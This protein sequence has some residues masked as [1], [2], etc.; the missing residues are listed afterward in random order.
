MLPFADIVADGIDV[1]FQPFYLAIVFDEHALV[2]AAKIHRATL[3]RKYYYRHL[4]A[5][6]HNS[7]AGFVVFV[8]CFFYRCAH[9]VQHHA[10]H[11]W[12]VGGFEVVDYVFECAHA[13]HAEHCARYAVSG[14]VGGYYH[15][16]TIDGGR[17]IPVAAYDVAWA[18]VHKTICKHFLDFRFV[19]NGF[20]LYF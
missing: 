10:G 13:E 17:I 9:L 6:V 4:H 14:T 11:H 2:C 3:R 16:V 8:E 15:F 12:V 20:R 5:V 19:A 18:V 7:L 1:A